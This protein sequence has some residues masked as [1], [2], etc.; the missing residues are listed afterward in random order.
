[1]SHLTLT[2]SNPKPITHSTTNP[3]FSTLTYAEL[4]DEIDR[5]KE[6]IG[7][8]LGLYTSSSQQEIKELKEKLRE[9]EKLLSESTRYIQLIVRVLLII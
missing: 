6:Q 2:Q 4:R 1:M 3:L 9:S 5:L 7:S 8:P